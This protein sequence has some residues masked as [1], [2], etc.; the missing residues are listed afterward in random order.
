MRLSMRLLSPT[1][2][3]APDLVGAS[4]HEGDD[5][6]LWLV[7]ENSTSSSSNSRPHRQS[8]NRLLLLLLSSEPQNL[9]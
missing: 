7:G 5:D 1:N 6:G 4:T 3:N 8:K 2:D 9:H